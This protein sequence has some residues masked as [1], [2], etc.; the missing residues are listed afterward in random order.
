MT[1]EELKGAI[2]TLDEKLG[3]IGRAGPRLA[4]AGINKGIKIL[5]KAIQAAAPLGPTRKIR[6]VAVKPG[7]L[8]A[9]I[10]SRGVKAAD[11]VAVAKAG[12]DV[13]KVKGSPITSHGHWV[14]LGTAERET[15][16]VRV[17][18][19][20]ITTGRKA[21]GKKVRRTG[22]VTAN[23]FV[24]RAS[25]AAEPAVLQAIIQ[26]VTAGVEREAIRQG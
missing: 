11:K 6:G 5:A 20:K 17:R 1:P 2:A 22:R 19:G 8:R 10:G 16:S 7:A 13:G 26:T 25:T 14:A 4:R 23:A 21:N 9:S 24:R 15:G 12:I 18:I 3:R